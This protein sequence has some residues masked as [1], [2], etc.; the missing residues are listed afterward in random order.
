[1]QGLTRLEECLGDFFSRETLEGDNQYACDTCNQKR[2]TP[3]P[4]PPAHHQHKPHPRPN[5]R[6][7]IRLPPLGFA[8]EALQGVGLGSQH[9]AKSALA[10]PSLTVAAP[11]P[12]ARPLS[13]SLG[14]ESGPRETRRTAR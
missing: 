4:H 5:T 2:S 1:M 12:E 14:P 10:R 7:P 13:R 8:A 6:P 3:R 9:P 11:D